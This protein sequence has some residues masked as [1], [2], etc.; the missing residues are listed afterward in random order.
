MQDVGAC[1]GLD[2]GLKSE[3][4]ARG[5]TNGDDDHSVCNFLIVILSRW[6][7]SVWKVGSRILNIFYFVAA[8]R[9]VY[10]I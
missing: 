7:Y 4:R 2:A 3:K 9:R 8:D 10:S 5:E 6:I 1:D